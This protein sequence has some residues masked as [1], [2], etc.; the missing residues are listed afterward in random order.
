M[1][2]ADSI[3]TENG[4]LTLT[5]GLINNLH[6]ETSTG[7]AVFSETCT[8]ASAVTFTISGDYTS[9]FSFGTKV[10]LTNSTLKYGT[11]SGSSYSAPNTTVTLFTNTDYSLASAAISGVYISRLKQP[12]GFPACFNYTSTT[13]SQAGTWTLSNLYVAQFSVDGSYV[14]LTIVYDGTLASSTAAYLTYTLPVASV[15]LPG[16]STAFQSSGI[17]AED[18]GTIGSGL[19]LILDASA[20]ARAYKLSNAAWG[21]TGTKYVSICTRYRAA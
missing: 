18:N 12:Q 13:N 6:D 14:D 16:A 11:V 21:T 19:T 7:W 17:Y 1:T 2:F 15:N 9:V 8:Y 5:G 3:L 10:K 4:N 20:T